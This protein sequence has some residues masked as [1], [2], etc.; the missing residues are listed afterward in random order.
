MLKVKEKNERKII[1][2]PI[3]KYRI[4]FFTESLPLI[5]WKLTK[6]S[7]SVEW[8]LHSIPKRSFEGF[9]CTIEVSFQPSIFLGCPFQVFNTPVKND[10]YLDKHAFIII[11]KVES[12]KWRITFKPAS[13]ITGR[14]RTSMVGG[15]LD[16]HGW[17]QWMSYKSGVVLDQRLKGSWCLL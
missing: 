16:H 10:S 11:N 14:T 8:Y 1:H 17:D 7:M 3:N 13:R 2:V 5:H 12:F 15:S 6:R 9:F 4:S